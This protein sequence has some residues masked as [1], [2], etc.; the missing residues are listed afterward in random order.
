MLRCFALARDSAPLR[1]TRYSPCCK[2]SNIFFGWELLSRARFCADYLITDSR[3][4]GLITQDR[5]R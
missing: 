1:L 3:A 5:N 4:S 2:L